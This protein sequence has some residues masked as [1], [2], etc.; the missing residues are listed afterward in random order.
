VFVLQFAANEKMKTHRD[1]FVLIFY[2]NII[3]MSRNIAQQ[4]IKPS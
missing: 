1:R 4:L 2:F 3:D